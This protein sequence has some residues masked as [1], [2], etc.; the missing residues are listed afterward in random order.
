MAVSPSP[1]PESE[2]HQSKPANPD[3]GA[4]WIGEGVSLVLRVA[5][6]GATDQKD[7]SRDQ[8]PPHHPSIARISLGDAPLHSRHSRERRARKVPIPPLA[9]GI[10]A[11]VH[12]RSG[13]GNL[14]RCIW[15]RET[16]HDV[17][18]AGA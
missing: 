4:P 16:L 17:D 6:A 9:S 5:L 15:L 2:A 1:T 11:W 3:D 8:C 18:G 13:T 7:G 14:S 10:S 12:G